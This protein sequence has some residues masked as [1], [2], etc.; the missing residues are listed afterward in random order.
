MA[1]LTVNDILAA[2]GLS[3]EDPRLELGEI[4]FILQDKRMTY[5]VQILG[6]VLFVN[7]RRPL[8]KAPNYQLLNTLN[9]HINLGTHKIA[10]NTYS[11]EFVTRIDGLTGDSGEL[12]IYI[13]YIR[14]QV[15]Q[16]FEI[17]NTTSEKKRSLLLEAHAHNRDAEQQNK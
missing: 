11:F 15:S 9:N 6:N 8:T 4:Y 5:T 13:E 3:P 12:R 2:A 16:G 7:A 14:R 10:G 17:M 1:D